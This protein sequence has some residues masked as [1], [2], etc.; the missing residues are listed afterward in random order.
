MAHILRFIFAYVKNIYR[1]HQHQI[2][3]I[4]SSPRLNPPFRL[5]Q[6]EKNIVDAGQAPFAFGA[7]QIEHPRIE[8]DALRARRSPGGSK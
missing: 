4:F 1:S 5:H 6:V 8:T 2:T 7:Q 3:G